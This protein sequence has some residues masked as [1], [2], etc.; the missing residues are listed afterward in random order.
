MSDDHDPDRRFSWANVPWVKV[1]ALPMIAGGILIVMV[2]I[3]LLSR[4]G[5]GTGEDREDEAVD[6]VVL[7]SNR[8]AF[9]GCSDCHEDLDRSLEGNPEL[10]FR[11]GKHFRTGISDCASC[12]PANTHEPDRTNL[13]KMVTCYMCHGRGEE[14]RAPGAC[15]T[16]HP[17]SIAAATAAHDEPMW[18]EELH[19][20]EVRVSAGFDCAACH[21]ERDCTSCHGLPMPHPPTF[22]HALHVDSYF[23]DPAVCETCHQVPPPTVDEQLAIRGRDDCDECHHPQGSSDEPWVSAHPVTVTARGADTCFQCH[24]PDTCATCHRSDVLDLTADQQKWTQENPN[25][26]GG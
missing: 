8:S 13:P 26:D 6:D 10:V 24:A 5:G 1:L 21:E 9:L 18:V 17:A 7:V 20:A 16:C 14:A 23:E 3:T 15:K 2:G 12:H 11:H 25:V 19:A 4:P 22:D